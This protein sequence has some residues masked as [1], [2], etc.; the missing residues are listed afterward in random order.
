[1]I[2]DLSVFLERAVQLEAEA[3]EGYDKLAAIMDELGNEEVAALFRKFAEF[4]RLH[5][6]DVEE[7]LHQAVGDQPPNNS[8]ENEFQ[9]PDGT[10][11]EDPQAALKNPDHFTP[12]KAL[13]LALDT[14]RRACDFY[15]AVA[16]QTRS[17]EV[18]ELAQAFAEEEA[19]HADHLRRW[20]QRMDNNG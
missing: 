12:R 2:D 17:E 5:L 7:R 20:L 18:Q 13:E 16:G 4:S 3:A 9:W 15:A 1:M 10:S 11:P 6:K 8:G 14:E 19:E